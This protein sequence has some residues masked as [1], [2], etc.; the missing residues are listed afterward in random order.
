[1]GTGSFYGATNNMTEFEGMGSI[2]NIQD[3]VNAVI[4]LDGTLAF[5]HPESG[6]GDDS[7]KTSSATY[8]FGYSKTEN[9]DLWKQAAP[10]THV[11]NIARPSVHQ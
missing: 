10:L 3:L 4:D 7:K 6:E 1:V 9:P 2:R 8:W 11:G 5:I